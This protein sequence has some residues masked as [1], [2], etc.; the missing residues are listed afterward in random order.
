MTSRYG[1]HVQTGSSGTG[2]KAASSVV[3]PP[4]AAEASEGPQGRHSGGRNRKWEDDSDTQ[5]TLH[6]PLMAAQLTRSALPDQLGKFA[7]SCA[8]HQPRNEET[9]FAPCG[10]ASEIGA[11]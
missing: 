7:A 2:S 9:K 1:V 3:S 5:A 8:A 6:S 10:I 4:G 11:M